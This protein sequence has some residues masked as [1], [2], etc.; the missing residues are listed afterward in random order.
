MLIR[1]VTTFNSRRWV[2]SPSSLCST[3]TRRGQRLLE[4]DELHTDP[5]VK[6]ENYQ[7]AFGNRACR[8]AVR[9]A[10]PVPELH[11]H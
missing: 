4:P 2:K 10:S 5:L 6:I 7:D 9:P 1:L 11:S 8:L 3:Y